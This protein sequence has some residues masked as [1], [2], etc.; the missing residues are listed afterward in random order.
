MTKITALVYEPSSGKITRIRSGNSENVLADVQDTNYVTTTDAVSPDT[1][2]VKNDQICV[3]PQKPG[4]YHEFDL[5]TESWILDLTQA[6]EAKWNEIKLSRDQHEYSQVTYNGNVYDVDAVSQQRIQGAF[7]ASQIDSSLV[8]TW[9][10]ADNTTVLLNAADIQ[11]LASTV[12]SHV[13]DCHAHART[14]RTDI[15]NAQT[16]SEIESITW[17]M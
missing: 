17:Q 16:L 12:I 15:D 13:N 7:T 9:T 3:Y 5:Q 10:L 11:G 14:L 6:R 4:E 1:H 2:Y 8:L